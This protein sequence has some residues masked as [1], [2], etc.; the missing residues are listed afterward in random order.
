M[1]GESELNLISPGPWVLAARRACAYVARPVHRRDRAQQKADFRV[2]DDD[3]SVSVRR[4]SPVVN[5]AG[6]GL[7]AALFLSE[8][9]F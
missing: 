6:R 7:A 8:L 5:R 3:V 1:V 2:R 4:N 9:F